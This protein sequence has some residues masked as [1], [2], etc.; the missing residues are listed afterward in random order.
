MVWGLGFRIWG[1]SKSG[2]LVW[3][4]PHDVGYSIWGVC[5]RVPLFM[6]TTIRGLLKKELILR[7]PLK[8]LERAC[9]TT[10]I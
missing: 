1:F 6:E 5:P 7:T 3:E 9:N 8:T 2:V 4:G 10:P